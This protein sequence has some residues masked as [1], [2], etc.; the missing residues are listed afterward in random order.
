VDWPSFN[1]THNFSSNV[2]EQGI[3]NQP[4]AMWNESTA[5]LTDVSVRGSTDHLYDFG[6]GYYP[7]FHYTTSKADDGPASADA[8]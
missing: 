3:G 4:G 8:F 2:R 6:K 1:L 7:V 5:Q